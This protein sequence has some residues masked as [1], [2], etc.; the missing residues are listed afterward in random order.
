MA[1]RDQRRK[2]PR[3]PHPQGNRQ[4]QGHSSSATNKKKHWQKK[5]NASQRHRAEDTGA[6]QAG[7][8]SAAFLAALEAQRESERQRQEQQQQ[9]LAVNQTAPQNEAESSERQLP[10]AAAVAPQRKAAQIPGYHYDEQQGR[11]FK[12]TPQ[13]KQQLKR[14]A[15][16]RRVQ[17]NEKNAA[18]SGLQHQVQRRRTAMK[19]W[20][21]YFRERES[22][23]RWTA[24]SRGYTDIMSRLFASDMAHSYL[25]PVYTS[26]PQFG[27]YIS[28]I[29]FS[30]TSAY[31]AIGFTGGRLDVVQLGYNEDQRLGVAAQ[32]KR[33]VTL[34]DQMRYSALKWRP[35]NRNRTSDEV[36]FARMGGLAGTVGVFQ[37]NSNETSYPPE[38]LFDDAR[39]VQWNPIRTGFFSVGFKGSKGG[40]AHVDMA[41]RVEDGVFSAPKGR[42]RSD[43]M[44]QAFFHDGN[45][46]FNGTRNGSTWLWDLRAH[47]RIQER[48]EFSKPMAY[49]VDLHIMSD[50]FQVLTQ[51][52]NGKSVLIDM[53]TYKTVV[54]FAAG[55]K[56]EYF[57]S[58]TCA[59]DDAETTVVATAAGA[60]GNDQAIPTV[61][62]YDIRSGTLLSQ[63]SI[64]ELSASG[65]TMPL[66]KVYLRPRC[67]SEAKNGLPEIWAL[68]RHNL[69]VSTDVNNQLGTD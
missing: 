46:I 54:E 41:V 69:F 26:V 14:A 67:G 16:K 57:S 22:R 45:T 27:Q 7:P 66:E 62:S 42:V 56:N 9:T 8:P 44:A 10:A 28:A 39:A 18:G 49:I 58:L 30:S 40:A 25:T 48:V 13:L 38:W 4:A 33:T 15:K 52:S 20:M 3:A 32:R 17:E 31:A 60:L 6:A 53:R 1:D 47:C 65:M 5:K 21:G 24:G 29:D 68:N 43:V 36:L 34:I 59:V 19:G 35:M 50:N 11:Y 61:S 2:K 63:V 23:C 51:W 12:L 64:N 37:V 55:S